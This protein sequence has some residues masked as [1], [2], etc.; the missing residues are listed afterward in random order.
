MKHG[1][2]PKNGPRSKSYY[3]WQRIIQRCHNPN[4]RDY[5]RYGAKGTQVCD[6]WRFGR[7]GISGFTFFMECMGEP[8]TD[9]HSI[10]RIDPFKHYSPDNCRWATPKEQCRNRR[11]N[12]KYHAFGETKT[13]A[14]WCEQFNISHQ[15]LRHR[16]NK[17]GLTIEEALTKPKYA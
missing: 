10:D 11:R 2:A 16:L 9:Y 4:H 1:M 17:M 8:P 6:E 15:C 7:D 3:R 12:T 5:G 13:Q 14:E